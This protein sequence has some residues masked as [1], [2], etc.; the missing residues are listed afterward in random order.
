MN[1]LNKGIAGVEIE[2]SGPSIT[3]VRQMVRDNNW[4]NCISVVPDGTSGVKAE[5]N[6][7]PLPNCPTTWNFYEQLSSALNN[8][9]ARVSVACGLHVHISNKLIAENVTADE[10][11]RTSLERWNTNRGAVLSLLEA[12]TMPFVLVKDILYR[13]NKNKAYINRFLAR[14]R[15]NNRF[16]RFIAPS[17]HPEGADVGLHYQ[18]MNANS[19]QELTAITNGKFSVVNLRPWTNGTIEFRQHQGTTDNIKIMNW[20]KFLLNFITHS[21][22]NR[23]EQSGQTS[24]NVTTPEMPFRRGT[25]IGVTYQLARREGGVSTQEIMDETGHTEGD[26]RRQFSEIRARFRELGLDDTRLIITHNQ[27][28]YGNRYG[29]GTNLNGYEILREFETLA[30]SEWRIKPDNT[31][32][33]DSIYGSLEDSVYEYIRSRMDNVR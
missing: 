25:R 2:V 20:I 32:G 28:S 16:C 1:Y 7:C 18:L 8:I 24:Q 31:I 6:V 33:T 15:H 26:V 30:T 27:Q 12:D 10:F 11:A 3:T 21:A 14:S 5:L 29:S 17:G 23:I 22:E 13:Y 19:I 4:E 9:N